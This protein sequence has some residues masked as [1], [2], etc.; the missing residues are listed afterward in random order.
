MDWPDYETYLFGTLQRLMPG[1]KVRQNVT[2]KGALSGRSR[3]VD[4]VVDRP[5]EGTSMSVAVDC[6][7]YKRKVNIKDVEAFLGMLE[8]LGIRKGALVTTKGYSKSAYNQ[9]QK[10]LPPN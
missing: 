3:Q 10:R 6:K 2:M 4:I 9:V 1:A 7:C 8:D 5:Y